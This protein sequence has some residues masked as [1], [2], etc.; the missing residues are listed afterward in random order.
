[1]GKLGKTLRQL[2][3]METNEAGKRLF[4]SMDANLFLSDTNFSF[5]KIYEEEAH[6]WMISIGA[7]L[8]KYWGNPILQFIRVQ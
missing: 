5:P 3:L 1:M 2:I 7:Y 4:V 8:H 6:D